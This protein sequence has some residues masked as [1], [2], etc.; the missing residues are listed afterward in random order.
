MSRGAGQLGGSGRASDKITEFL[1]GD[2]KAFANGDSS[3]DAALADKET[4]KF[5]FKVG[6]LT[7]IDKVF[8]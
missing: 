6:V 7:S 2:N 5:Y 1:K 4:R 8:F 3:L